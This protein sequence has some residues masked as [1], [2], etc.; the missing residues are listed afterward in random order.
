MAH[1]SDPHSERCLSVPQP[2][3]SS[4][5]TGT[6]D[7]IN[8]YDRPSS[9]LTGQRIWIY[10]TIPP[11]SIPGI[12]DRVQVVIGSVEIY[13]CIDG[14]DSQLPGVRKTPGSKAWLIRNPLVFPD[15]VPCR[16]VHSHFAPA[17]CNPPSVI[18]QLRRAEATAVTPHEWQV[19]QDRRDRAAYFERADADWRMAH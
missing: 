10:V 5:V 17:D 11:R 12:K 4:V 13:D 18:D 2:W 8:R 3:A 14:E 7:V 9:W 15:P 16:S 6:R 19:M 1:S